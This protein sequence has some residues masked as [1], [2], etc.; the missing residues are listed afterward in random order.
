[1]PAILVWGK[2]FEIRMTSLREGSCYEEVF[3]KEGGSAAISWAS[4]RSIE[5]AALQLGIESDMWPIYDC[6]V[7]RDVPL[8]E[9]IIL[10]SH[11]RRHLAD[12]SDAELKC[13]DFWLT[14][15][16]T[17]VKQGYDFFIMA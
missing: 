4:V 11:I 15:I 9:A 3:G 8:D 10:S 17:L 16:L 7:D 1:M 14:R 6:E 2:G 13:Q 12:I 5:A